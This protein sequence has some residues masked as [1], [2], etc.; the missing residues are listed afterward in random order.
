M[1]REKMICFCGHDCSCC[2]TYFATI[3]DDNNLLF[4]A[5]QFYKNEFGFDI[6]LE[7]I[8]YLGGRSDRIFGL[9]L[10]CPWMKC[11]KG[12]AINFCS[13]CEDYP[14]APLMDYK[15]KFVNKCHQI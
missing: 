9:C 6:P 14:C 1:N 4:R 13:E 2:I 12:R 8:Q 7:D 3:N 5:Q 15:D 11:C 10:N